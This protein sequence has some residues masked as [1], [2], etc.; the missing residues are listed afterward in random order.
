MASNGYVNDKCNR[1]DG[2]GELWS[3]PSFPGIKFVVSREH[4]KTIVPFI[5]EEKFCWKFNDQAIEQGTDKQGNEFSEGTSLVRNNCLMLRNY[6]NWTK[7]SRCSILTCPFRSSPWR[8]LCSKRYIHR[9]THLSR[10]SSR[11]IREEDPTEG[12]VCAA[13]EESSLPGSSI[14]P[15]W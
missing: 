9:S 15:R 6:E 10:S 11:R 12:R 4:P 8:K 2:S 5:T 7:M 1:C 13:A 14:Y 3:L